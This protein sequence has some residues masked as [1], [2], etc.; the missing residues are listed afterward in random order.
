MQLAYPLPDPTDRR[1]AKA[2]GLMERVL[3]WLKMFEGM[4]NCWNRIPLKNSLNEIGKKGAQKKAEM[5]RLYG[6]VEL[7]CISL[8]WIC[9]MKHDK[10]GRVQGYMIQ[11]VFESHMSTE[12]GSIEI[13]CRVHCAHIQQFWTNHWSMGFG[14]YDS[15][16]YFCIKNFYQFSIDGQPVYLLRLGILAGTESDIFCFRWNRVCWSSLKR[17]NISLQKISTSPTRQVDV[18][19]RCF[20]HV[21]PVCNNHILSTIM[22]QR[23]ELT[24]VDWL[25]ESY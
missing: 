6:C 5:L 9:C 21:L 4:L 19:F 24:W 13:P 1:E 16:Q 20:W 22:R 12:K 18:F 15:V 7:I 3:Q 11:Y 23:L 14:T 25:L 17:C 8:Q 2:G 10:R